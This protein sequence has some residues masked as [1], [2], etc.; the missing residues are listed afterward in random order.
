M[1]GHACKNNGQCTL[2]LMDLFLFL[3]FKKRGHNVGWVGMGGEFVRSWGM[4]SI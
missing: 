1:E 3:F 2:D 4:G